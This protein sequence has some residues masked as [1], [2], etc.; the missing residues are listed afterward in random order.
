MD[1]S[2]SVKVSKRYLITV[3]Q[4]ARKCLNIQAG[5]RLLV[6]IQDGLIV[7]ELEPHSY[8]DALE[9]LHKDIWIY[10][11]VQDYIDREQMAWTERVWKQESG[12]HSPQ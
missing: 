6:D 8:T 10:V 4:L 12:Q 5:D 11:D 9:G 3:P 2:I 1:A 7:L